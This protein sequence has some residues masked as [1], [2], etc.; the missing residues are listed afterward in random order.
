MGEVSSCISICNEGDT[1]KK[2]QELGRFEFGGSSH[3]I[4]FDKKAKLRFNKQIYD[5]DEANDPV[6]QK[7]GTWL[8]EAL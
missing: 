5:K 8:A 4:I 1:L 6:L 3:A 2:G 7:V